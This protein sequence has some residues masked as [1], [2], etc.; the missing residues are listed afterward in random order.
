MLPFI[1][2]SKRSLNLAQRSVWS[3]HEQGFNERQLGRIECA[4]RAA[5]GIRLQLSAFRSLNP[6]VHGGF[7]DGK[8][9]TN[10]AIASLRVRVVRSDH[11][12]AQFH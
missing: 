8:H 7:S 3:F 11:S 5:N 12:L 2:G 4:H 10:L 1:L 6:A 9:L